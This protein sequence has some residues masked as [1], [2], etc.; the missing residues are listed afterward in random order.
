MTLFRFMSSK[1]FADYLDGKVLINN[2]KHQG[3]T[4]SYGFCFLNYDEYKPNDAIKF[5]SGIVSFDVCAVFETKKEL[6]ESYGLYH[7]PKSYPAERFV[8]KEYCTTMYDNKKMK[9]V[10]YATDVYEKWLKGFTAGKNEEFNWKEVD[11]NE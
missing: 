9:L 8:A 7:K 5:L 10:K 2:K 1:E 6:H 4:F 3:Q 11:T